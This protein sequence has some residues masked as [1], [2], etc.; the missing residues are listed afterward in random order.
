[1][2]V[3]AMGFRLTAAE[4][5]LHIVDRLRHFVFRRRKKA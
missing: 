2:F 4:R 3:G 1:M 5:S